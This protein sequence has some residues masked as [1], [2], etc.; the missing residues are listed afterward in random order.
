MQ[1]AKQ[2]M[3]KR[4]H[5]ICK[6]WCVITFSF[7]EYVV[8]LY[9]DLKICENKFILLFLYVDNLLLTCKDI[10]LLIAT[11]HFLLREFYSKDDGKVSFI[12]GI[13][14]CDRIHVFWVCRKEF[15]WIV[16]W[17]DLKWQIILPATPLLAKLISLIVIDLHDIDLGLWRITYMHI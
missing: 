13:D 1:V 7:V 3:S 14:H 10:G 8:D 11:K 4:Q 5:S 6:V 12:L 9:I 17:N 16:C 15:M 2:F